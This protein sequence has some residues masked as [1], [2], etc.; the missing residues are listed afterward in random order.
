MKKTFLIVLSA[1][2]LVGTMQ[3]AALAGS[4]GQQQMMKSGDKGTTTPIEQKD[5]MGMGSEQQS[6]PDSVR[7]R[8]ND[9]E[10]EILKLRQQ[11]RTLQREMAEQMQ[12]SK[13][14]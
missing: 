1:C 12:K 7:W 14:E 5:Y 9:Q 8:L 2:F 4:A 10:R 6:V 3:F 11:V 13:H